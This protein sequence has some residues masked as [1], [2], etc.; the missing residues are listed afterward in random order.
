MH[1]GLP[2]LS[3]AAQE[4]NLFWIIM[5]HIDLYEII[6]N[7]NK[8]KKDIYTFYNLL[9]HIIEVIQMSVITSW[10]ELSVPSY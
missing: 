10:L 1:A 9:L 2:V 5:V 3:W 7:C 8:G 4:G 6:W